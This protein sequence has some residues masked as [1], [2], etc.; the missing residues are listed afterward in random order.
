[1]RLR[2]VEVESRSSEAE[3]AGDWDILGCFVVGHAY[4]A[5]LT[6]SVSHSGF[7][8]AAKACHATDTTLPRGA[9]CLRGPLSGFGFSQRLRSGRESMPRAW[10][11]LSRAS[12]ASGPG[13]RDR[14]RREAG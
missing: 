6:A 2:D 5:H 3:V 13:S 12:G 11:T 14:K 7:G 10:A 8:W 1:M 9:A 4:A